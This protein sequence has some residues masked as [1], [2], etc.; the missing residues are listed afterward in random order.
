MLLFPV[1]LMLMIWIVVGVIFGMVAFP[2]SIIEECQGIGKIFAVISCPILMLPGIIF[3]PIEVSET[4][5]SI[6]IEIMEIW[7]VG[8][9]S[10]WVSMSPREICRNY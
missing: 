1:G 3:G 5:N 10:M 4:F 6:I 9:C 7:S 8:L 2:C